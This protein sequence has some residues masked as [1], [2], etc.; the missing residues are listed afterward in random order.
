M[1]LATRMRTEAFSTGGWRNPKSPNC[2]ST[3]C[4][5]A[6]LGYLGGIF[7]GATP[8][9]RKSCVQ[10]RITATAARFQQRRAE[11]GGK[12]ST[13]AAEPR[14]S[15][16]RGVWGD[17]HAQL[18]SQTLRNNIW[19]VVFVLPFSACPARGV[20]RSAHGS[21]SSQRAGVYGV[22]RMRKLFIRVI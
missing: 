7:V 5:L 15:G 13:A 9:S 20:S 14:A 18:L 17:Q 6:G 10:K 2:S 19:W 21:R 22:G 3:P 11:G 4:H 16:L 12:R 8:S 1:D